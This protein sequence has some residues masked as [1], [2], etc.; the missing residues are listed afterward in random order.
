MGNNSWD[1][2]LALNANLALADGIKACI[3]LMILVLLLLELEFL[4]A[5]CITLS[6]VLILEPYN[7]NSVGIPLVSSKPHFSKFSPFGIMCLVHESEST[8]FWHDNELISSYSRS[9]HGLVM[10]ALGA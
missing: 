1:S 7:K 6:Q 10:A 2:N 3:R 4:R 9:F 5:D 8:R